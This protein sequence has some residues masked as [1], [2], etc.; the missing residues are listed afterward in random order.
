[1]FP[2]RDH[3]PSRRTPFVTWSLI[4]LNVA[5]FLATLPYFA[6][7]RLLGALYWNWGLVPAR[8]S[9]GEGFGGILTSMFLHGGWLHLGG[10]MLFLWIFGDNLEDQFGHLP[11]LGFYLA[12]GIGAA[13]AQYVAAP[14][15]L[16]PMVGASGA[17]AGVLGGYLLLFPKA[18]VD[19]LLI[20]IVFVRILVLPAWV[21]LGYW[22]V[23]QAVSGYA[24]L[25]S[26]GG[27]VAYLAHAG[28]F[29]AGALL[30]LP[31]WL[32]AGGPRFWHRCHGFPP[33]GAGRPVTIRQTTIPRVRRK[34]RGS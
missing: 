6:D 28:G 33:H 16:V 4:A 11:F 27:G 15:S 9:A 29:V 21:M 3:N 2:I 10:N 19:V 30:A 24:S 14:F 25:G 31:W 22:F 5:I 8:I 7:D 20:I 32:R 1:M 23:L 26:D 13:L 18:R 34:R 12:S 17:I